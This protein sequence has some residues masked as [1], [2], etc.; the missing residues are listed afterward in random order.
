VIQRALVVAKGAAI[1]PTDLPFDAAGA[2]AD[3]ATVAEAMED[4]TAIS[5]QIFAWRARIRE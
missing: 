3:A 4:L 5:R 1:L 2:S